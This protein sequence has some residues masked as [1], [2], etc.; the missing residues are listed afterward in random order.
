MA[1]RVS[2]TIGQG[3]EGA[4]VTTMAVRRVTSGVRRSGRRIR[5]TKKKNHPGRIVAQASRRLLTTMPKA[6]AQCASC[7]HQRQKSVRATSH[8]ASRARKVQR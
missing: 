2:R 1:S 6:E 8:K 7:S 3:S 4:L 5:P